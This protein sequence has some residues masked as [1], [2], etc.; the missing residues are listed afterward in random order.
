[1][2]YFGIYMTHHSYGS[3]RYV[4]QEFHLALRRLFTKGQYGEIPIYHR[5]DEAKGESLL[6][7]D[8]CGVEVRI[9]ISRTKDGYHLNTQVGFKGSEDM[10]PRADRSLRLRRSKSGRLS[11]RVMDQ[12]AL[13]SF[14]HMREFYRAKRSDSK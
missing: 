7:Y 6:F 11:Q 1:M 4:G 5:D 3:M 10:E 8:T 9:L 13:E 12:V 14:R 2:R